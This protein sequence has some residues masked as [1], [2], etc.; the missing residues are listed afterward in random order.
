MQLP[1]TILSLD[2]HEKKNKQAKLSEKQQRKNGSESEVAS[3]KLSKPDEG[4]ASSTD[5]GQEDATESTSETSS[6]SGSG[7]I[8][9]DV[10]IA[11]EITVPAADK[12]EN[13]SKPPK[14]KSSK[15]SGLRP[16][17]TLE[18]TLFDRLE[19][20]YGPGIKRL[21]NVQYRYAS[22]IPRSFSLGSSS[23]RMHAQ[24]CQFPSNTLYG[25]KLKSHDS[26]SSHLLSDLPNTRAFS[27]TRDDETV[28]EILGTPVIFFDTAG[29]EYYERLEGD[30]DEGSRCNE[31]EAA[32]VKRW[33][34]KLVRVHQPYQ[35]LRIIIC[36]ISVRRAIGWSGA[37]SLP[38]SD[39][40]AVRT[41]DSDIFL[42][43]SMLQLVLDIG[44]KPR[45]PSLVR[46]CVPNMVPSSRSARW[47]A[48][49][50]AKRML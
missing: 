20:M 15:R 33:T 32:V 50:D 1:P 44:I 25:S 39:R 38:D 41:S 30:G 34:E 27:E 48:C 49:K 12:P 5:D 11:E 22:T 6:E 10:A 17:R 14:K 8:Y 47:T 18:T 29:C 7:S 24:I 31:N 36:S 35:S 42:H 21:L 46:C 23:R 26:V 9:G 45:S 16:P 40:Y 2:K 43:L 37:V 4:K 13:S 19:R 3:T 28:K